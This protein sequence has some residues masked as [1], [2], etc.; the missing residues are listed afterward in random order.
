MAGPDPLNPEPARRPGMPERWAGVWVAV[1][2]F[3]A[4]LLISSLTAGGA[5]SATGYSPSSSAPIPLAVSAADLLGLWAGLLGAVVIYSRVWGRRS[6]VADYGFRLGAWWDVPLGVAVGLACQYALVPLLYL[7][8]EQFNHHLA[9]ELGQ[10]TTRDT[11]AVHTL[12]GAVVLFLFLAVGAPLVEELFFRG[13]LLRSIA[14]TVSAPVAIVVSGLLFGLA[15]FEPI[16]FAGLAL[17]GIVF[18]CL[19]WYFKRLAPSISAHMAFNA[20]AVFTA[21]H[22]H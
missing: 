7:P 22:L 2:G 17:V 8:F 11:G 5:E 16:Q 4:G 15:H 19:A 9:H 10:P 12:G 14:R 13:L 20:V 1:L 21:V 18:G 6:L 3:A